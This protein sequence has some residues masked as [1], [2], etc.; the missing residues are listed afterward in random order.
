MKVECAD[1]MD[2]S[3]VCVATVSKVVG[4]LLRINFDG[5][6]EMYDQ[7]LD[8]ESPDMYPVGWCFLVKHRL[9][10]PPVPAR[11]IKPPQKLAPA[12]GRRGKQ[13]KLK[14]EQSSTGN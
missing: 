4:R 11:N 10:G 1:L 5:W 13:K 3:L 8:V 2:P 6:E 7:W 12:K 14:A 9:E